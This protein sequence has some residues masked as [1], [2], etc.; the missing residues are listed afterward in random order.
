MRGGFFFN[1]FFYKVRI[2]E[3]E[4]KFI[5]SLD[6]SQAIALHIL[7]TQYQKLSTW[8]LHNYAPSF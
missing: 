7:F 3:C 5:F 6:Q 1:F 2:W 4:I 8:N